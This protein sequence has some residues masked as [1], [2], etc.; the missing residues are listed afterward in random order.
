MFIRPTDVVAFPA[1]TWVDRAGNTHFALQSRKAG[2]YVQNIFGALSVSV[3]T[4]SKANAA[5][6]KAMNEYE[7]R[8]LLKCSS[9]KIEYV[10][11]VDETFEKIH[12][13]WN[14]VERNLFLKANL[15]QKGEKI[16]PAQIEAMLLKQFEEINDEFSDPKASGGQNKSTEMKAQMEQAFPSLKDE[17][18]IDFN[19]ATY[20]GNDTTPIRGTLLVTRNFVNFIST[21]APADS[22]AN[23]TTRI[24]IAF[25]DIIA[26]DVVAAKR[27]LTPD[28]IQI[29]IKERSYPFALYLKRKEV[30]R[31]LLALSDSAMNRL[32]KGSENSAISTSDMYSK[33]NTTGDL[34]NSGVTRGGGLLAGRSRDD[35][36]F[37]LT[38]MGST[39]SVDIEEEDF[40]TIKAVDARDQ[41]STELLAKRRASKSETS[42]H[43]EKVTH[44]ASFVSVEEIFNSED[45]DLQLKNIEFRYLFRLPAVQSVVSAVGASITGGGGSNSLLFPEAANPDPIFSLAIPFSQ[46]VSVKKQPPTALPPEAGRI[47]SINLSGYLV[48]STRSKKEYWISFTSI[49]GRDRATEEVL[50]RMKSVDWRFEEELTIGTRNGYMKIMAKKDSNVEP[51]NDAAASLT[52]FLSA[53]SESEGV[54]SRSVKAGVMGTHDTAIVPI[55]LVFLFDDGYGDTTSREL[56]KLRAEVKR[57]LKESNMERFLP[58]R[59]EELEERENQYRLQKQAEKTWHAYFESCG[60]DICMSRDFK[61]LRDL[62]VKTNGVPDLFRGDFWLVASGAWNSRPEKTY[63]SNMV[64]RHLGV[65]SPFT[66]EI[67]KDV[68]RS[69][70]EHSAYQSTI[71]IDALRRLLTTYSW[72]NPAIGYAQALNIISAVLLLYL[73]EEDAF[74]LLSTIIERILPDQYTKTLVGSV[75]DQSVYTHLVQVH[76]PALAAHMAKLYMDLST[77]SVPWFLCLFLN[78]VPIKFGVKFLDSFFLDGPK[79]LFWLSMAILK[80]NEKEL[81]SRGR[82]DDIFM[83]ILKEF[84]VRLVDE[85]SEPPP[86]DTGIRASF[87]IKNRD[88]ANFDFT[89]MKGRYLYDALLSTAYSFAP[90]ITT[91]Q[92]DSLRA[93]FRLKVVHQME[94]TSRKSQV[95]TLSEQVSLSMDELG[96]V[97]NLVRNIEFANEGSVKQGDKNLQSNLSE[98]EKLRADL[99]RRGA[100]GLVDTTQKKKKGS[101]SGELAQT[102]T[103][104]ISLSDF[105]KI[106]R[107]VSPWRSRDKAQKAKINP[108]DMAALQQPSSSNKVEPETFQL[109]LVDR[110]YF[111]CSFNYSFFHANKSSPQGGMGA[112]YMNSFKESGVGGST[113]T[114]NYVVDLATIVHTLDII[115]KQPLH[116]RVRFLFDLHDVDGDGFLSRDELKTLMDSLLE[117]FEMTPQQQV[118]V[119]QDETEQFMRSVTSF[120]SSALKLGENKG[121]QNLSPSDHGDIGGTTGSGIRKSFT[122]SYGLSS[123]AERNSPSP[124]R[125]PSKLYPESAL[126]RR[127]SRSLSFGAS[128]APAFTDTHTEDPQEIS[129]AAADPQSYR[130]SF[131]EFLLAML[132][133]TSFVQYFERIWSLTLDSGGLIILQY[134][135]K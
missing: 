7:F 28:C 122:V 71:G 73:R 132:S 43:K 107:E 85:S 62:I 70:P 12:Q 30:L 101:I 67:E 129:H 24:S 135:K 134:L 99:M 50:N 55:G 84:F 106:C 25:K 115:M 42:L 131:N 20:W 83:T 112:E 75:V 113:P 22:A 87:D 56:V 90:Y 127:Q 18:L 19:P 37:G 93:K 5:F 38:R 109:P 74:W 120:V 111:Y 40:T 21:G 72:R 41:S 110:I 14:W 114:S 133:Q 102:A 17:T 6:I 126:T 15:E 51:G 39:T 86:T 58:L 53:L 49:K 78:S 124:E 119:T 1:A 9:K 89:A 45:V 123:N 48:I 88:F 59:P 23:A 96:I 64:M 66:D 36:S 57:Q 29:T 63:Y 34:A 125:S 8:I 26:L 2:S 97:Y 3:S 27:V 80:V 98:E 33:T 116:G 81:I 13:D 77:I 128:T 44:N 103:K 91:D 11:A 61:Y 46:I 52:D 105:R 95:R 60:N 10:V 104:S 69:L 76:M 92:I 54:A 65:A 100:W 82:D 94:E 79:F 117:L 16:Q 47:S 118:K 35:V 108:F 121:A 130:L 4:A 32:V 31:L 68:R